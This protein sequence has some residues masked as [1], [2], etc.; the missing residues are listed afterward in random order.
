MIWNPG[1]V[2]VGTDGSACSDLAVEWAAGAAFTRDAALQIVYAHRTTADRHADESAPME[3]AREVLERAERVAEKAGPG[4]R[5]DTELTHDSPAH[6][7]I[8]ASASASLVVVG[9]RGHGGFHDMLLGSTSLETAMHAICPVAVIRPYRSPRRPDARIVV[10]VD[11]APEALPAL[12]FAFE[13]AAR[14]GRGVTAVHA[15]VGPIESPG[16]GAMPYI[17]DLDGQRERESELLRKAVEPWRLRY[18]DEDIEYRA[19]SASAAG[20]LVVASDEAHLVVVGSRGHGGFTG[21][22]LGS[23]AVALIHHAGCPVIIAHSRQPE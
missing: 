4:L 12:D 20:A 2:V 10:G 9:N 11:G 6:S 3:M 23:A 15:W 18:P 16:P 22:L 7:L 19:V 17:V 1:A 8:E 21:M 14:S 13:E 5:I